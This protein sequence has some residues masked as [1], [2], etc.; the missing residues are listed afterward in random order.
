M[1]NHVTNIIKI[2]DL[3]ETA[4]SE[5][6]SH[7]LNDKS[8]I[9]FNMIVPSPPCLDDFN[10]HGGIIDSAKMALGLFTQPK[11]EAESLSDLTDNLALSNACRRM[12]T[13]VPAEDFDDILRAIQNYKDCG[14]MMWYDWNCEHWGTKW[15]AY[16]QPDNGWPEDTNEFKFET[17]WSHP[18]D[19]ISKLSE[20][21]PCV[22]FLISFAD[23]DLGSNCGQYLIKN[24]VISNADFAGPW[25]EMSKEE[26]RKY[27]QMAFSIRHPDDEPRSRGY[28]E[29]WEYSDEVYEA[30]E[31]ESLEKL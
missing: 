5:I 29:N 22:E 11:A 18:A 16:S 15:N 2:V 17:A 27:T 12:T 8:L 24:G 3:G 6:R 23:E 31:K 26:Q 21:L 30:Y 13:E 10:P 20:R 9:D 25:K 19:L 14:H 28:D 1:P 7:L 4:L